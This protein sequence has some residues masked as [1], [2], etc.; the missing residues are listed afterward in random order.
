MA[1]VLALGPRRWAGTPVVAPGRTEAVAVDVVWSIV[2]SAL[3]MVSVWSCHEIGWRESSQ[4]GLLL[5]TRTCSLLVTIRINRRW[6]T[7]PR[8]RNGGASSLSSLGGR[9]EG[10][11]VNGLR[12]RYG[13]G[14]GFGGLVD[15]RGVLHTG[16]DIVLFDDGSGEEACED[17]RWEGDGH[18]STTSCSIRGRHVNVDVM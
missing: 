18:E 13:C 1:P 17:G 10:V 8:R 2:P 4:S 16:D 15:G 12:S 11:G 14:V 9:S 5:R 3:L 6:S 7:F